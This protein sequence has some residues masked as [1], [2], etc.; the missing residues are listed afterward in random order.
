[1]DFS[2]F[3][4]FLVKG[5]SDLIRICLGA[6]P[7]RNEHPNSKSLLVSI[8][9]RRVGKSQLYIAVNPIHTF[10]HCSTCLPVS[11]VQRIGPQ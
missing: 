2:D 10:G 3:Y 1:M 5:V 11:W 7:T 6:Q 4:G 9:G 8:L